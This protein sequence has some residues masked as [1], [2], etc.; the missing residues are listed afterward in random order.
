MPIYVQASCGSDARKDE[1]YLQVQVYKTFW[2]FHT[3]FCGKRYCLTR[4]DFDLNIS[5]QIMKTICA[6][7]F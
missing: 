5:P 1:T 4:L 2:L 3:M 6:V 7:L